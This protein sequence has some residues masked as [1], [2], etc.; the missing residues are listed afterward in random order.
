MLYGPRKSRS[1]IPLPFPSPK[2]D[3]FAF[4]S[5]SDG[6]RNF[7]GHFLTLIDWSVDN[8]VHCLTSNNIYA[9]DDWRALRLEGF[10]FE[11]SG[12]YALNVIEQEK[13]DTLDACER[14]RTRM[15]FYW[16]Y[17]CELLTRL[18]IFDILKDQ[19]H[20]FQCFVY[21]L[22]ARLSIKS[23]HRFSIDYLWKL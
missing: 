8:V 13:D 4:L 18:S 3:L 11:Q 10:L 17:L 12:I 16:I 14:I 19:W 9:R 7:R 23:Q 22:W 6:G 2:F 20:W 5:V 1:Q 21:L 15:S